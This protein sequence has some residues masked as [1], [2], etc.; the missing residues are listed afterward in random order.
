VRHTAINFAPG[1]TS[2]FLVPLAAHSREIAKR[3]FGV[4]RLA[5]AFPFFD[6]TRVSNDIEPPKKSGRAADQSGDES[7]HSK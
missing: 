7:Q 4:R 2:S 1:D 5:A 3:G 6:R